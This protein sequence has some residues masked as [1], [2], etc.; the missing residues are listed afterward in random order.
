MVE[1]GSQASGVQRGDILVSPSVKELHLHLQGHIRSTG[2]IVT[3]SAL[4]SHN[5]IRPGHYVVKIPCIG[6]TAAA[7][8]VLKDDQT[9]TMDRRMAHC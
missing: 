1:A 7:A 9:S 3:N 6:D 4:G 2:G 8:K 5:L